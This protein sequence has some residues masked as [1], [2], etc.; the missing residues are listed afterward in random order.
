MLCCGEGFIVSVR[1]SCFGGESVI[2]PLC[3]V[4]FSSLLNS[5]LAIREKGHYRI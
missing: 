4:C 5:N 2:L 1:Q 3:S